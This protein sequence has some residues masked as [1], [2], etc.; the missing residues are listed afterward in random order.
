MAKKYLHW[1][2]STSIDLFGCDLKLI[3]KPQPIKK[4]VSG[5]I[6]KINMTAHG[7]CYIERF[8]QGN[9][10]GLSAMQFIETSSITVHCDEPQCRAFIDIFS[11]KDFDEKK[12][13][14]F[15]VSYFKAKTSKAK[16]TYR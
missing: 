15:A 16:T 9:L 11:C 8:G 13:Q 14:K 12:A 2:K 3:S 1:G 4:F 7:P 5:I 10:E 6:K